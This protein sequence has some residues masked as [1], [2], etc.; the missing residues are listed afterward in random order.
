MA[1]ILKSDTPYLDAACE[2][3]VRLAGVAKGNLRQ[4][5]IDTEILGYEIQKGA[6]VFMN[7]HVDRRPV[8]VDLSKRTLGSQAST[9]KHGDGFQTDAGHDLGDFEPRRW[10]VGEKGTGKEDFN[11]YTL[12]LLA[13]GGGYRGCADKFLD[14]A[15]FFVHDPFT[16]LLTHIDAGCS[17]C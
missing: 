3:L 15:L 13:Y 9:D 12:P 5:I 2:E 17:S 1:D 16:S 4:A 6:E 10:L 8:P 11:A 7:Y 14:R